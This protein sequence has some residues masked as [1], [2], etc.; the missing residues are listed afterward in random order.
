LS[1]LKIIKKKGGSKM[2]KM[3]FAVFAMCLSFAVFAQSEIQTF[4]SVVKDSKSLEVNVPSTRVTY[5]TMGWNDFLT[6]STQVW[7]YGWNGGGY[8]FGTS[9]NLGGG[10]ILNTFAQGYLNDA[11]ASFGVVG[12]WIWVSDVDIL[13]A[14]G[15]TIQIKMKG[16]TG[17][18]SYTVG[19]VNHDIT[20]PGGADLA[21]GSF[22]INDVDTVW[23]SA[24][25][26]IGVDFTAPVLIQ[27]GQDFALVFDA[28]NCTTLSDTIG[29]MASDEGVA[30]MI[31]GKEYTFVYY[32]ALTNYALYDHLITNGCTR[33]P[34][35]FAIIDLDYV[36]V[37]DVDFFQGM[38]LTLAPNPTSD[39]LTLAYAVNKNTNA[40][41]EIYDMG[42]RV[43]YSADY[44][45]VTSGDYST[46]ID[47][48]EFAQGQYLC[49]VVSDM[50]RLTKKLIVK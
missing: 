43:V 27:P 18:S 47:I 19:G 45:Y 48:S 2:K 17:T 13:S 22:N 36:N 26:L 30:D 37:E 46:T 38:Q 7:S 35:L 25:G 33:M 21:T 16:M 31:F 5:D 6:Y 29:V 1:K 40:K 9:G 32:P 11:T 44:G 49:C 20:C 41:V 14:G 4:E 34:G 10:T 42:G 12:A 39:I 24:A 23:A 8:I 3:Y 28:S 15:C 50:G